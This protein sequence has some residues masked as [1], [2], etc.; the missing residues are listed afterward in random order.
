MTRCA[1]AF[2]ARGACQNSD[3]MLELK[4]VTGLKPPLSTGKVCLGVSFKLCSKT[5]TVLQKLATN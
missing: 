2:A 3:N 1:G 5:Q 4:F